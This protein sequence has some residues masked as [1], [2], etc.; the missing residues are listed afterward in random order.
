MARQLHQ[1]SSVQDRFAARIQQ[2]VQGEREAAQERI[3]H[4]LPLFGKLLAPVAGLVFDVDQ[5]VNQ[6]KGDRGEARVCDY[7]QYSLPD[8][9]II[10]HNAV[11]EPEP[12]TFAQVDN[13]LIGP[14]GVFCIE[15]KAW[16]GSFTAYRNTWKRREGQG[17][18]PCASPTKQAIRH[19]IL[20]RQWLGTFGNLALPAQS[21]R[22]VQPLV[23]FTHAE[24]LGLT[25]CTVPVFHG[26]RAL[27]SHLQAQREQHL[28]PSQI[29]A[30][31]DLVMRTLPPPPARATPPTA[32]HPQRS[33]P[34]EARVPAHGTAR[35][36]PLCPR[37]GVPLV[38]RTAKIG[39]H[40]GQQFYGC[41]NF[42]TCRELQ[43]LG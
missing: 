6:L 40:A 22:W 14:P 10:F 2:K 18:T 23:V 38:L 26:A 9:W 4:R 16:R 12:A 13:L 27:L 33:A 41:P 30:I 32:L 19:A 34:A 20:M 15:T 21:N 5:G 1:L 42:P 11:I 37:C 39:A 8:A 24:W 3:A 28:V 31:A 17:W 29:D 35:H 7:I 43:A 36:A 25:D